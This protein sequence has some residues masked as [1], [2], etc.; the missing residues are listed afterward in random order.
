MER[1]KRKNEI[2]NQIR[3]KLLRVSGYFI[4]SWFAH[5]FIDV[6]VIVVAASPEYVCVLA[7]GFA[8]IKHSMFEQFNP[9]EI[10]FTVLRSHQPYTPTHITYTHI[11]ALVHSR[12]RT[13]ANIK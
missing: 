5:L 13:R 1:R 10:R 6:V 4:S 8:N 11:S 7:C 9:K 2:Q 3:S 12:H